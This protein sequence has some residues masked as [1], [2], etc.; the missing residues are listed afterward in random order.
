MRIIHLAVI[1]IV[2]DPRNIITSLMDY[3]NLQ[4]RKPKEEALD[5]LQVTNNILG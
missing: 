5:F 4:K 2:R 3:F 1:H